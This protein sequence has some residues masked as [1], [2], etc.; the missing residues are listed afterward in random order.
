LYSTTHFFEERIL[1][2]FSL[3][4]LLGFATFLGCNSG[5]E[6]PP[7]VPAEGVVTLDGQPVSEAAVIFIADVGSYNASGITDKNGTFKLKAF[8]EKAGAVPGSYKVEITKTIIEQTTTKA[9]ES[10][11][12]VKYGVPVKYAS[13]ATSDFAIKLSDKGDKEIKFDLKSK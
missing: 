8:E 9:G 5:P 12:N 2:S 7:T 6:R 11:A 10:G 4:V 3:F 1:K 13:M